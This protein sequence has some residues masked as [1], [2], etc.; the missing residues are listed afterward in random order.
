MVN[1]TPIQSF[2]KTPQLSPLPKEQ[3]LEGSSTGLSK[4][5]S[6][7]S[8]NPLAFLRASSLFTVNSRRIGLNMV[9]AVVG[10]CQ[11]I[12]RR[13]FFAF[14]ES[15]SASNT[16]HRV[17][18]FTTG[19]A[20]AGEGAERYRSSAS[21]A[22]AF[23][24]II[25]DCSHTQ[26]FPWF[27]GSS[28]L[29]TQAVSLPRLLDTGFLNAPTHADTQHNRSNLTVRTLPSL[30]Y[31]V[32]PSGTPLFSNRIPDAVA[33]ARQDPILQSPCSATSYP[34]FFSNMTIMI[35]ANKARSSSSGSNSA[36]FSI[37]KCLSNNEGFFTAR[38]AFVP[39]AANTK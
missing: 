37:S 35:N 18:S 36:S 17:S 33:P 39:S 7:F 13:F 4:I 8:R 3:R 19:V 20:L 16:S 9:T 32:S 27:C 38:N 34:R 26:C 28:D 10:T 2:H 14:T 23:D 1:K 15:M 31:H 24:K 11:A 5:V 6:Q 12:P 22:R 25:R 21:S 30:R 29:A